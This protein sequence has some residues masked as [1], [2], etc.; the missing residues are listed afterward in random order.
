MMARESDLERIRAALK[1][2][3]PPANHR[4]RPS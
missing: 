4:R 3:A 2:E 1:P